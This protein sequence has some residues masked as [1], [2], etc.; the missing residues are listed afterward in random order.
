MH[1][2]RNG[3]A[4]VAA[5]D[6]ARI[7]KHSELGHMDSSSTPSRSPESSKHP[8][9]RC[10]EARHISNILHG[11]PSIS[12][13]LDYPVHAL[14]PLREVVEA[15]HRLT[16]APVAIAAQSALAVAALAAQ[17]HADVRTFHGSS[18]L[19]LFLMSIARSGERKSACDTLMMLGVQEFE[20]ELG[21]CYGAERA[22]FERR[23]QAWTTRRDRML[24]GAKDECPD[25]LAQRIEDD[26]GPEPEPP[27]V[28]IITASDPTFEGLTRLFSEGRPSLGVFTDEGGSFIG[29]FSM[30]SE[31]RL[32]TMSGFSKLWD[33]API[34]RTRALDGSA[35]LRGRRLSKHFMVQPLPAK[36]LL[37]DPL[38]REQGYLG[39][40]LMVEP[41]SEI[42][43]R[44]NVYDNNGSRT[45]VETHRQEVLERLRIDMPL[46][47]GIRQELTPRLI[48]WSP[49]AHEIFIEFYR[50]IERAQAR[51][52]IYEDLTSHASK[53]SEQAARLATVLAWWENPDVARL[54]AWH[55]KMGCTLA[56]FYLNEALRIYRN[57]QASLDEEQA[58]KLADWLHEQWPEKARDNGRGDG[59]IVTRRDCQQFG[60][61]ALR[62]T[63]LL[64][65]LF[66]LLIEDGFLAEERG[67]QSGAKAGQRYRILGYP[68][69]NPR[70]HSPV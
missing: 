4:S 13:Q 62:D 16:Q 70:Q 7:Q 48:D 6:G 64:K 52:G 59:M 44:L 24:R 33:G 63:K 10:G 40:F 34:N 47:S 49:E 9:T 43:R 58:R 67:E 51:N 28:P 66:A 27:L 32:H 61:N 55:A 12:R 65:R 31:K 14:G 57:A 42:G 25:A 5:E 17:A 22:R 36:Q 54:E 15:V 50:K 53:A 46:K 30:T 41:L 37:A 11:D 56:E 45:C 29:G 3:P 39:R 19:S 38:A 69:G 20:S 18:P 2:N 23:H 8:H 26:L 68:D 60:P 21:E 1:D 35:T